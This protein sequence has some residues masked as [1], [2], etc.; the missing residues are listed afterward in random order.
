M[1]SCCHIYDGKVWKEFQ[2]LDE[3]PF[4]SLPNNL[5]IG[6]GCDWF[7]PYKHVTYLYSDFDPLSVSFHMAGR[8]RYSDHII[9]SSMTRTDKGSIISAYWPTTGVNEMNTLCASQIMGDLHFGVVE[10]FFEHTVT[11]NH[12]ESKTH[13]FACVKWAR[14]HAQQHWFG[15]SATVCENEY[16]DSSFCN[17]IPLQR[18]VSVCAHAYLQLRFPA[19]TDNV[20]VAIPS[21]ALFSTA[22]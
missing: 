17:Y 19:F 5:A 1:K 12:T 22:Q 7:Q 9:H 21:I 20:L 10:Y 2:T 15:Q 6:L 18:I 14:P 8:A 13:I 3:K 11:R 16:E 4:L